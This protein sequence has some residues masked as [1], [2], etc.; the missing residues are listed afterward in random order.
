[1]ITDGERIAIMPVAEWC[2]R[3]SGCLGGPLRPQ[4]PQS[5]TLHSFAPFWLVQLNPNPSLALTHPLPP[6]ADIGREGDPLGSREGRRHIHVRPARSIFSNALNL[7]RSACGL[8]PLGVT[9]LPVPV[10]GRAAATAC[11]V[12]QPA[13]PFLCRR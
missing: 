1:V 3:G 11:A 4:G 7:C 9:I 12:V 6:G 8:G 5:L 10:A 13:A 2:T